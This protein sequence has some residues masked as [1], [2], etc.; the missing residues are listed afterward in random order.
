[1]QAILDFITAHQAILAGFG[2]AVLDLIFALIPGVQ[3]NGFLHWLYNL[4]KAP[5]AGA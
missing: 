3:S 4:L 2:V 1:M 5:K